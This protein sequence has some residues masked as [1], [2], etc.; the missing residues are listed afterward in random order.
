MKKTH[1]RPHPKFFTFE[2]GDG[3]GKTTLIEAVYAH[4]KAEGLD[5]L[6]TRAPGG[7]TL[8]AQ[9]RHLLL[10]EK[11]LPISK[12]AEILLFLADR[13]QHV[14]EVILPA[15]N[16]NRIVLCDRFNDSTLAYQSGA[17]GL[18][19]QDVR[20]L[21][22]FACDHLQPSLTLYLDIDPKLGLERCLGSKDRIESEKLSFHQEI[23]GA[24]HRI[25]KLEPNRFKI[26]DASRSKEE[27]F[28]QALHYITPLIRAL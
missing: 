5:P 11:E 8:G 27:V 1:P 10:E 21:L 28:A 18:E 9:I 12:R 16:A 4:L 25:A 13:A 14:D 2:G 19:E 22:D 26:L 23:R 7:T 24:Y 6:W 3:A 17:R 15:L 20:A